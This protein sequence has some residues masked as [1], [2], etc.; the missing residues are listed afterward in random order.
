[1]CEFF[2]RLER[3]HAIDV[4]SVPDRMVD[5]RSFALDEIKRQPHRR[6]GQQQIREQDRRIDVDEIDRLH[7]DSGG[8][9]RLGAD[10]QQRVTLT[11][12]TVLGHVAPGLAH[13]PDRRGVYGLTPA[14]AEEAIVHYATS[15]LASAI[16][17]SSHSG[18]KRIEAPRVLSSCWIGSD[19]K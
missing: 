8:Q 7:R 16:R 4:S 5:R 13:E 9:L 14:G 1:M 3:M 17:S 15:V 12:R 10:L 18:L 6:E 11:Q 2:A 19:R